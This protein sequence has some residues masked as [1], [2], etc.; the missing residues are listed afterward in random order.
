MVFNALERVFTLKTWAITYYTNP[1]LIHLQR[2]YLQRHDSIC[3]REH[4]S[5]G[6]GVLPHLRS[7]GSQIKALKALEH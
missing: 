2:L 5:G 7:F 1:L 6:G 4:Y 3:C